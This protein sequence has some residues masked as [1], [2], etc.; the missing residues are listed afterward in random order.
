MSPNRSKPKVQECIQRDDY[1]LNNSWRKEVHMKSLS[2]RNISFTF[3]NR[4]HILL[5]TQSN[6]FNQIKSSLNSFENS[7]SHRW[8]NE[9]IKVFHSPL[10]P[11]NSFSLHPIYSSHIN[12]PVWV[13]LRNN[14]SFTNSEQYQIPRLILELEPNLIKSLKMENFINASLTAYTCL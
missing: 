10:L 6:F 9:K 3:S 13:G 1:C 7:K 8:T 4:L 12:K 2:R 11:L 14:S 5:L